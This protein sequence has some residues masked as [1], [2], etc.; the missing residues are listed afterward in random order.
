VLLAE[1]DLPVFVYRV[2]SLKK[3]RAQLKR[4]GWKPGDEFEIPHGPCAIFE[5]E[6]GQRMAIYELTRTGATD[7]FLGRFDA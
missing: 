1:R 7:H 2:A 6:G 5:A 4:R 3:T